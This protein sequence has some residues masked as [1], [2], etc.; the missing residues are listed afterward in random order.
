VTITGLLIANRG[1]IAIRVAR[2]AAER[3]LRTVAVFSEDDARSLHTR[4]ADVA[5]PLRGRGAAAYL[6]AEG[7]VAAAREAGC[8]AVHPGYGFLAESAAFARRCADAGLVFVGPAPGTLELF[9]DKARA[10]A[11][12]ERC[13]VPVLPGTAGSTGLGEARE[14]LAAAG[15]DAGIVVKAVAGGGGR[16]MRRVR[17]PDEL[18]AAFEACAR[19]ARVAFGDDALYVERWIPRARHVEV[20]IAGDGSGQVVHLGDRECSV[21]RRHQKLVEVAP[22]PFLSP[23]LRAHLADAAVRI[24][25]AAR[26]AGVGTVEFLIDAD[27]AAAGSV[28]SCFAFIEANARLQVEHTVTEE[29]TGVDLVKLQLDLAVGRPLA[30]LGL[31]EPPALR[32]HAIQLRVNA[33]TLAPDGRTLPA[34][35][36]LRAFEPPTGPGLR[37][38]TAAYAGYTTNP[39]FDS[40]LAKVVV[41]AASADFADAVGRAYRALCELR[42]EGVATNVPVLLN[43]LRHPDF[44]EGRVTT[45]FV[46]DHA[47]ELARDDAGH[48][49]LYFDDA[50]P[51][52][53]PA[54]RAAGGGRGGDPLAV[55]EHGKTAGAAAAEPAAP[56]GSAAVRSP[57]Q[58][59]V[60]S[61]A[62]GE[63]DRVAR[64]VPLLVLEAMKMEHVIEADRSGVVRGVA[65]AAGD[66]VAEGTPLVFLEEAE[67]AGRTASAEESVD[68]DHVR[69]DLAEVEE[70]HAL[71]R[72]ARR[73]DAVAR[74]RK[75]GQRTAREN[76]A[77]LCDPGSFVEYGPLVIAAQRRRRPVQELVEKTPADGLVT[78]V[79]TVNGSAFGE[80]GGR[81]VVVAYDYTVLAGTQGLQNHRKKDRMFELA[82]QWRL[83][84]VIF[85]EGGGGRPGDTDGSGVAGLDCWAFHDFGRL[86]GLVPLVGINSGRCFAGNAALLGCCDVVI[87]TRGSNIGMGGPAMIEGGGLGVFRPEEV[88]PMD[89][90][91]PGG[92]VDVPVE[93]EAEAVA[94]A[95]RYLAYFQG[96]VSGGECADPRLLRHVIPENRLRVYDVR[97]VIELLA[98][99]GSVLELRR[100]FGP[101][102]VTALARVEG[103]P[104]GIVANNPMHLAGAIDSDGA[105][106]AAR[107][108]QLCDAFDLPVLFLC[109]TPGI[110]V[111]PEAETTALVRHASR[112]FV[113]GANLSVP[114]FTIVLRKGYGLGAQAMAG[115]SFKAPFF[116]VSW[117]TGEFGGMGLEG[118][119]KLGYRK[120]LAA[121]EDP[122]ERRALFEEMVGRMY[123]HGKAV[124]MADHFEIDEVIDPAD[125]RRWILRAL[126]SAPPAAPRTGKKRPHVDTW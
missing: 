67:V 62:V 77:D 1:E 86:S 70:R 7:L 71:G 65:V 52:A 18:A 3:G 106:K 22:S 50:A 51:D 93:D 21:Q 87:A 32:G 17:T 19:E 28:A 8:D 96:P 103:L 37:T 33:E 112:L 27:A 100:A 81:C 57:L 44:R 5:V 43:L 49:R 15:P 99:T 78:G 89:V 42:V 56:E 9:G 124:S 4:K 6:D 46:E 105:D 85:T 55:L 116:C 10:R 101:G 115:G 60:V 47:A 63:G 109:D 11:L 23:A 84:V 108:L 117:P 54:R 41:H 125:S 104:L 61:L 119:V 111:G 98:D 97:R 13:G 79:G 16:G 88:G 118:A 34:S 72:D 40:L 113:T 92:V 64:G 48:A 107:F 29:V 53:S 83:P 59:T 25:E 36:T 80:E 30:A 75:T 38:D 31:D 91:V 94:V 126:R 76:V 95:R 102:M 24:G 45:R 12:A 123:E 82:L 20:Q 26:Y 2:A 69:P 74:R 68:P 73:P 14:F 90:Q 114:S 110:M 122:A 120:E 58:G 66:T 121:V 39:A 35:G